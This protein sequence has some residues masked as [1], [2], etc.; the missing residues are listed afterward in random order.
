MVSENTIQLSWLN[1]TDEI[2]REIDQKQPHYMLI[3]IWPKHLTPSTMPCYWKFFN[4]IHHAILN[5]LKSNLYDRNKYE[6]DG[7]AVVESYRNM[8][9][10]KLI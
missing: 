3:Q 7:L 8:C 6:Y 9:V 10:T 1:F 5:W 2:C 4:I